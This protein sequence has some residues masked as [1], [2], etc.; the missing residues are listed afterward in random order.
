MDDNG[1]YRPGLVAV[2]ELGVKS[3]LRHMELSKA[4]IRELSHRLGLPNLNRQILATR[5][6]VGQYKVDVAQ[7]RIHEINPDAVVHTYKT[8]YAPQ[9]AAQFDFTQYDYI[10]DTI[11]TVTGKL[12]LIEQAQR[13]GSHHQQHGRGQQDGRRRVRGGGH[14]RDVGLSAGAGHAA[15]AQEARHQAP[16]GRL[17]QGAAHHAARRY[18]HQLPDALYLP[19][20][21]GAQVYAAAAGSRQ[22]RLRPCGGRS[23]RRGRGREGSER[24]GVTAPAPA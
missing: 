4:E 24:V 5:K 16:E 14:L 10:V 23:D 17:L 22:Q 21:D 7:E 3:P 15:G 20:G 19:A 18:V 11:D 12:E 2:R 13:Q 1:D 6:T 8:F 9:T